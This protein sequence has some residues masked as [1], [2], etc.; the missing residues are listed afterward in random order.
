MPGDQFLNASFK[1][2][3]ADL[4]NLQSIAS[5][6]TAYTELDIKKLALRKLAPNQQDYPAKAVRHS[7]KRIALDRIAQH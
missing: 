4:A 5:Q 7:G 6:N 1:P 2:G 3:A